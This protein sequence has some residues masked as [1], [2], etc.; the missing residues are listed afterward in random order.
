VVTETEPPLPV[1]V[2]EPVELPLAVSAVPADAAVTL[3]ALSVIVPPLPVNG[4]ART[5]RPLARE[6]IPE[7]TFRLT[8]WT[9]GLLWTLI[10]P[11]LVDVTL[12]V[13]A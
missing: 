9:T 5:V 7:T 8:F 3:G 4:S 2:P 13:E 11:E 1:T 12:K 10:D 6:I